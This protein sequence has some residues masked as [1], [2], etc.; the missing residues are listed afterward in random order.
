MTWI[1]PER[2]TGIIRTLPF[3]E[4]PTGS[5]TR[6]FRFLERTGEGEIWIALP[7]K[8]RLEVLH[9]YIVVAGQVRVRAN[10]AGYDESGVSLRCWDGT[11]RTAKIWAV[12]TA[13]ISYPP[14]P[15][16]MRGFRGFRYT[17]DLW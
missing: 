3:S 17:G 5:M 1:R 9:C 7:T 11:E 14:E 2:P 16:K 12:L 8:P 4:K 6:D 10:I 15:I 13:P